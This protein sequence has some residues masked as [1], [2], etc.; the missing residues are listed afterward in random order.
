MDRI[1]EA[2]EKRKREQ[3]IN[4]E[5][6]AAKQLKR[7]GM[8]F[9]SK[10]R[11]L[12][13]SYLNMLK[14]NQLFEADD[15]MK[16]QYNKSHSAL[17]KTDM[18]GFY[19]NVYAKEMTFGGPRGPILEESE[20]IHIDINMDGAN[21]EDENAPKVTEKIELKADLASNEEKKDPS[22][23]SMNPM[24]ERSRSRSK[25]RQNERAAEEGDNTNIEVKPANAPILSREEKIKL[26]KERLLQR[27]SKP[28]SENQV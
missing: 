8:D 18:S 20:G 9:E 22:S 2:A 4:Y 10:D 23:L 1:K 21:S 17:N 15:S 3:T 26:A 19:R 6:I 11:F 14:E 25:E 16:E 7:E 13:E 27:R 12:T 5:K 24:R 28:D